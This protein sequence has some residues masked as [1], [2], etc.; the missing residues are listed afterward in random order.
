MSMRAAR[1]YH[2][3]LFRI[4][5]PI[6]AWVSILHRLSGAVLALAVPVL[7]YAF[8][9]S[10]RSEPDF[11]RLIAFLQG[12]VVH[13][14]LLGTI[15]AT[16]HHLLAGLRHLGLDL[17]R[18]AQRARARQTALACLVLGVGLTGAIAIWMM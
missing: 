13:S 3:D 10:L 8:M 16:L 11:D 7:L 12:G 18:G 5:Q 2:L 1:P 9:L 6:G 15:W 4:R 14:L 17:G